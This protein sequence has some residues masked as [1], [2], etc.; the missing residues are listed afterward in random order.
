MG[1]GKDRKINGGR[2]RGFPRSLCCFP[3]S[4]SSLTCSPKPVLHMGLFCLRITH[5]N[6]QKDIST[7][8]SLVF[9]LNVRFP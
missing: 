2:E 3:D 8:A 5:E 7:V 1:K 4:K 6:L 9:S